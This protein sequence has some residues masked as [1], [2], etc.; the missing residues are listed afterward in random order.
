MVPPT[1]VLVM[2]RQFVGV[3]FKAFQNV[4]G[5]N[6]QIGCAFCSGNG[7]D[8]ASAQHEGLFTRRHGGLHT[9]GVKHPGSGLAIKHRF[10]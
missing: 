1:A 6:A 7:T 9:P 3:A 5:L 4:V 8:A 10:N 2:M